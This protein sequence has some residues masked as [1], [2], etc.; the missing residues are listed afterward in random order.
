MNKPT[1]DAEQ[2]PSSEKAP[3]LKLNKES[4]RVLVVRTSL[5]T[6]RASTDT[7]HQTEC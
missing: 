6:G 4:I 2:K 3:K 5:R 1:E 7:C